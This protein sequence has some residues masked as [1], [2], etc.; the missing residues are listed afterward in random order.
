LAGWEESD[1]AE[2]GAAPPGWRLPRSGRL[3]LG[4]SLALAIS[5][6]ALFLIVRAQPEGDWFAMLRGADPRYLVLCFSL[7]VASWVADAARYLVLGRGLGHSL[8]LRVLVAVIMM[9]NFM[10]LSTPFMAGGVPALIYVLHREGLAPGQATAVV[11]T[12][13]I[14]SQ[15]ALAGFNLWAA[16]HLSTKLA[17]GAWLGQAY[18]GFVVVYFALL[19]AF[20]LAALRVERLRPRMNSWLA[21]REQSHW[22]TRLARLG[23]S[24]IGDFR[25]SLVQLTGR[26]FLRL[27]QAIVFA[28]MYFLFY[29]AV[30]IAALRALGVAGDPASLFAW[31]I[32]AATIALFTPS[33]GGSGAAEL[34]AMYAFG[35][36]LPGAVLP[37]FII[38]WRLFTFHANLLLGG[39]A[40]A[41]LAGRM[42]L[43]GGHRR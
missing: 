2:D 21:R 3:I 36:I 32:V 9:G 11:V 43:E 27:F 25:Q 20:I 35:Q 5:A 7:L 40:T 24:M 13:G 6:V 16:V 8:R 18:L 10:T 17:P 30:G 38:L 1:L 31:Q 12:G 4:I 29:F 26:G 15:L 41:W 37:A 39:M 22:L 28:A 23:V 34:G 42:S 19:G 14:A 33:P